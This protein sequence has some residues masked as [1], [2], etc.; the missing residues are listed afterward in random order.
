MTRCR[1]CA[2][3]KEYAERGLGE[4]PARIL[5]VENWLPEASWSW[6]IVIRG[7][8]ANLPKSY[9]FTRIMRGVCRCPNPKCNADFTRTVD[10]ELVRD[11]DIVFPHNPDT[12]QLIPDGGNIVCR[13]GGL[14]MENVQRDRYAKEFKRVKAIIA[15]NNALADIARE[16][17]P[18][19]TVI[20]NGVDLEL[21][22]PG[23]P[24]PN[25]DREFTIGFAGNVWGPGAE[26]KGWKFFVEAAVKLGLEGVQ[27][28]YLLHG[29]N[30]IT[31]DDMPEEFYHKID[32][33]VL[34]SIGEG[35]SNVIT[36]ALA[37]GVPCILTK[38]GY[39][40][41]RLEDGVNCL[42]V[43][44]DV[45]QILKAVRTL[46]ESREMRS[47]I[48]TKSREFAESNHDIRKVARMYDEVFRFVLTR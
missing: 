27:Q 3:A 17:N 29:A 7:L 5:S 45:G 30:Q 46:I 34:P 19:V 15:T 20:P 13:I 43:E 1:D 31:H 16:S 4:S 10:T 8:I 41:E 14:V 39:H 23:E 40:G 26:Y 24:N 44:R 11:Y 12:V 9:L 6:G 48:A 32:A 25:F 21:F 18:N 47:R 35:C 42:F 36:E 33:M 38:V 22:C 28:R 37:C 2:A